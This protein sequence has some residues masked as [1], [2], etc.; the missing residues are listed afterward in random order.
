M[1]ESEIDKAIPYL[2]KL[3]T[4]ISQL[5]TGKLR[6]SYR[7]KSLNIPKKF[8]LFSLFKKKVTINQKVSTTAKRRQVRKQSYIKDGY[9][10]TIKLY[11]VSDGKNQYYEFFADIKYGDEIRKKEYYRTFTDIDKAK[12]HYEDMKGVFKILRRRELMEKLFTEKLKEIK[13]LKN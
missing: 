11:C 13:S 2:D 4:E 5:K 12:K 9:T 7:S 8:S 3:N 1:I 10:F 6:G